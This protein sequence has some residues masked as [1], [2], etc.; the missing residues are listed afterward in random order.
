MVGRTCYPGA[1]RVN[2]LVSFSVLFVWSVWCCCGCVLLCF[3]FPL[4]WLF[5]LGVLGLLLSKGS[6]WFC[7]FLSLP[8]DAALLP[9]FPLNFKKKKKKKKN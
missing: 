4:F 1:R 3:C 2:G 8:F 5:F 6:D 7:V 9:L